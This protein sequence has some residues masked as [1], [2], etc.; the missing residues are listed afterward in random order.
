MTTTTPARY[1]PAPGREYSYPLSDYARATAA[2]LG[3]GWDAESSYLGAWGLIFTTDGRVSL[4]LYV[5]TDGDLGDLVFED[6]ATGDVHLVPSEHIP[7]FS[8]SNPDEMA[9]WG[10]DLALFVLSLGL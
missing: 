7:D 6:R 2:A 10:G 5:D 9:E 1:N 4:R 8:P 3:K